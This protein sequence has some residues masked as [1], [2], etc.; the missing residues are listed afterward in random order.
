MTLLYADDVFQTHETGQHPENARR[1]DRLLEQIGDSEKPFDTC[2]RVDWENATDVQL[3]RVHDAAYVRH[4]QTFAADGGGRL[5]PDTV[6]SPVSHDVARRA[7]GAVVDATR[8]VLAGEDKTAFCLVRPPGHH[9]LPDRAMGFCLFN[10]IAVA[11]EFARQ[12]VGLDRVLIVDFDVHHGNGTQ[13]TFYDSAAVGFLSMH[14]VPFYPFTGEAG[15]TGSGDGLGTTRNVPIDYGTARQT[16]LDRF[17][18]ALEEIANRLKPQ[19]ILLSAGF[20]SHKDD[21]IGSLQLE[22]NDFRHLTRSVLAVA[23]QHCEGKLVSTL[24]G[25]YNPNAL[26][27]CVAIHVEELLADD[28]ASSSK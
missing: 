17:E 19:L 12:D 10:H 20:D 23:R 9:A 11:A 22:T 16:Q 18:Q 8:R 3:T 25:G 27:D 13:D 2:K 21:P 5:D 7:S 28:P 14:R 1:I 26:T 4:V 24:E 15:E 6:V